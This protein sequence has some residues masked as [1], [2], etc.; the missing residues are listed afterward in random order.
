MFCSPSSPPGVGCSTSGVLVP[1]TGPS[2][3]PPPS[4]PFPIRVP[5]HCVFHIF[6]MLQ[7]RV[8]WHCVFH[9]PMLQIQVPWLVFSTFF[10]YFSHIAVSVVP[11]DSDT[12]CLP[13]LP[14]SYGFVFLPASAQFL[15]VLIRSPPLPQLVSNI[16]P[17]IR[18]FND[19]TPL[20]FRY[21]E[22]T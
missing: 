8:P 18:L 12:G 7:I 2:L 21:I 9:F 22:T 5:W 16:F 13:S 1:V 20:S 15:L 14:G 4:S 3:R 19:Y 17:M 11:A 10:P 6:L